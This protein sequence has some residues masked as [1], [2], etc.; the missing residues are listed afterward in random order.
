M[1][2]LHLLEAIVAPPPRYPDLYAVA[3][4]AYSCVHFAAAYMGLILWQW[5]ASMQEPE[6]TP[7]DSVSLAEVARR[8]QPLVVRYSMRARQEKQL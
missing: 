2:L 1:A 3:F 5:Q 8:A 7:M 6:H 4:A